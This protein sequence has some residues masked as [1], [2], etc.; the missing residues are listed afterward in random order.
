MQ[1]IKLSHLIEC[2]WSMPSDLSDS[3]YNLLFIETGKG[4]YKIEERVFSIFSGSFFSLSA[5]VIDTSKL[6]GTGWRIIFT[7]ADEA[8]KLA[9]N[10]KAEQVSIPARYSLNCSERISL[11]EQE[12]N[13]NQIYR[14][15]YLRINL[16]LI[17]L[18]INRILSHEL[19][20]C[21]PLVSEAINFIESNY[22]RPISLADVA[23]FV[24]RSASYLTNLFREETGSTVLEWIVKRRMRKAQSLL[25]ET[26]NTIEEISQ[27]VGYSDLRYFNRKF[28]E[29]HGIPPGKWRHIKQYKTKKEITHQ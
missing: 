12:F 3:F 18:D 20:Y 7:D 6:Y 28:K 25:V 19:W 27:K 16:E 8:Q 24:N 13:S 11:I 17:L 22:T 9:H 2:N 4:V 29:M 14:E 10:P 21:N 15:E 26:N 1:I 5:K 23:K